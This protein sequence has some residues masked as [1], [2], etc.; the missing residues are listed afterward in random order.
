MLRA[1]GRAVPLSLAQA[2][3]D[4]G[5]DKD[6]SSVYQLYGFGHRGGKAGS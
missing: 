1:L 4:V 6:F 3:A 5:G 2:A